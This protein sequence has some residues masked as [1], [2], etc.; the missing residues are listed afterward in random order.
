MSTVLEEVRAERWPLAGAFTIARGSRTEAEVVVVTVMDGEYSGRGEAV[1]YAR[2]G[3]TTSGVMADIRNGCSSV[4]DLTRDALLTAMPAG[5]ARNAIDCA[6]LDLE[7][8]RSGAPAASLLE[9]PWLGEPMV[10]CFTISLASPDDMAQAARTARD[11]Q[12]LK[13]KLG[14]G[15]VDAERLLAVRAARPDARLVADANESWSAADLEQLMAVCAEVKLEVLEQPLPA[16][17]DAPL[18]RVKRLVPVCADEGAHTATDIAR[19]AGR[20]DAVNIK[21]DKAGGITS[22]VGM[23]D[24]ARGAGLDVMVG[25]MVGTSLAMAPAWLLAP[26]AR[27]LDLDGPLLLAGDRSP[28]ITYSRG[29]L[30]APP[31]RELWG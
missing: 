1:P 16:A 14:G 26:W 15:A 30:M 20:Y 27:W 29:G 13:L 2:Y 4:E 10:T 28:A 11:K 7:A 31:P 22:A 23:A 6:L 19:I 9:I 8:K 5:A 25:C 12:L 18:S 24:A 21:L 3:E 17:A